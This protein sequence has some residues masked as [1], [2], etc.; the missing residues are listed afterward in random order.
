MAAGYFMLHKKYSLYH[1]VLDITTI[2]VS[3]QYEL[4]KKDRIALLWA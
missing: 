3:Y 2:Q 4:D 1:C